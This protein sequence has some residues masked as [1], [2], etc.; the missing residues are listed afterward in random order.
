MVATFPNKPTSFSVCS[1]RFT[2]NELFLSNEKYHWVIETSIPETVLRISY[3]FDFGNY[4]YWWSAITRW[5]IERHSIGDRNLLHLDVCFNMKSIIPL[6]LQF[7][8]SLPG[9]PCVCECL[10]NQ[11]FK[12]KWV[13][14]L[15]LPLYSLTKLPIRLVHCEPR[16]NQSWL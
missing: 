12:C 5:Y 11:T 14:F 2:A 4:G 1:K 9:H 16:I 8:N 3:L 7:T 10:N 6:I 13:V 15:A